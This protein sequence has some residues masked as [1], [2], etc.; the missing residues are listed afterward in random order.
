MIQSAFELDSR[1]APLPAPIPA[2]I[3]RRPH[4]ISNS[5]MAPFR[6]KKSLPRKITKFQFFAFMYQQGEESLVG[7]SQTVGNS[8]LD[9]VLPQQTACL[10]FRQKKSLSVN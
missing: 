3:S 6:I 1:L 7:R 2:S 5:C 9:Q 8:S 10:S 4:K